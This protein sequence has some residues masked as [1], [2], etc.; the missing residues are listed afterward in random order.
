MRKYLYIF[1]IIMVGMTGCNSEKN[2]TSDS[3]KENIQSEQ[4]ENTKPKEK[5]GF[6][7]KRTSIL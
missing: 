1:L 4:K 3:P 7:E 2:S 5:D 6:R